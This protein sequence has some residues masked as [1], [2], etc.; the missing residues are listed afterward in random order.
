ML[1][2]SGNGALHAAALLCKQ[3]LEAAEDPTPQQGAHA[4][5]DLQ[6]GPCS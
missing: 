5:C 3:V 6:Q 4:I 1:L 2:H